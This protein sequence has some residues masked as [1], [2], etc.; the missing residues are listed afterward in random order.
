[1]FALDLQ[2][3]PRRTGA[4]RALTTAIGFI[5]LLSAGCL[6]GAA[7]DRTNRAAITIYMSALICTD[8]G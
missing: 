1:M 2:T 3:A 5:L 6:P 4:S 8:M 7:R